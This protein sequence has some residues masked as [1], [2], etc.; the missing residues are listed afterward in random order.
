MNPKA[1]V[2]IVTVTPVESKSVIQA[3]KD[4]TGNAPKMEH[5]GD[6]TYHNLGEVNGMSVYMAISQMGSGGVGGSQETVRKGIEALRP[7]SVIMVGIAFG[8]NP[9]KQRIGDILV[10]Q[11]LR[12]YDLQRVGKDEIILRGD[13]PHGSA[14]LFNWLQSAF[15]YWDESGGRFKPGVVLTG[16]KLVDN[17]D[18]RNQLLQLEKEAIGG[19]ME[20]T[21]LY[22]ASHDKKVDWIL[23]KAI[24]DWADGDKDNP[25]KDDYQKTAAHNAANFVVFALQQVAIKLEPITSAAAGIPLSYNAPAK[26]AHSNLPHQPYFFG[27]AKELA[28]IAEAIGPEART[29]GALIDG[30]GGIGKTSLAIRAGHLAPEGY[31]ARKLFLS[32]KVRE[33]TPAGEQKLE[34]FM[35]PNFMALLTELARELGEDG[36]EKLPP[37]ER[38]MA[39]RNTLTGQRVLLVVD[40]LE[41]FDEKERVRLYQFLSHLPTTCKAI[42]T[43]RRRSDVDART[44]RLD[45]LER[46]EALEL[47]EELA[48]L[49]RHLEAA[50][51]KERNDLYETTNGNPLLI[52]WT[53]GQ[54][55]R[56]HCRSVPDAITFLEAAP[57]D[58]DPLEYI[59]G[60]LLDSFTDSE[61]AVLVALT[62]FTLPAK[63]KWIAETAGIAEKAAQTA[64]EDLA[65]RAL[66]IA[67]PDAEK[68]LLPPLAA[69]FLRRKCPELLAD[70]GKRLAD[71]VFALVM[72]NGY[73]EYKHFPILE[74]E[75]DIIAVTIPMFLQGENGR[76]QKVCDGL[77]D[78]MNFS[79]RWDELANL[80]QQG[81]EKAVADGDAYNAGCRAYHQGFLY[82]LW[83]QANEVLKAAAHCASHWE[84]ANFS[85]AGEKVN[86]TRLRGL[87][88]QLEKNYP[89]AM[90]AHHESLAAWR[91]IDRESEEV[92]MALNDLALVEWNQCNYDASK[93]YFLEALRIAKKGNYKESIATFTG[94]LAR[95][96]LDCEDWSGAETL[97]R[98]S[99]S[100]TE[101]LGRM[102]LIASD[103]RN[104]AKALAR[105]GKPQKGL[106]YAQRAVE[107]FSLLRMPDN[108]AN[109]QDILAECGG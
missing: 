20:G 63:I 108:L 38:A 91:A 40:N 58:N 31:F 70:A 33:L 89:A 48:T 42:V 6:R 85:E 3:F 104:L 8:V 17:V 46:N 2:L 10:S 77:L 73:H 45:R 72:E 21:G 34:D 95:L 79:G 15:L 94:N 35:L 56:G 98:K 9:K 52:K 76:L 29:W 66:L 99:L 16:E 75:W 19:E 86:A 87:G 107:I 90:A 14:R 30:P 67:T 24:C 41:T 80:N 84:K 97:A 59:F 54:L 93:R 101:K 4:A 103:S 69:T 11:Q 64:L 68:Y 105:Q 51:T 83:G 65:D 57:K 71:S 109:A 23:V 55:G 102:E 26:P 13:K 88:H 18:Y 62:Y 5:I 37:N 100:L 92:A 44:I 61:K 74:A 32:A 28:S 78:F 49:N 27:R 43:S 81:E 50:T 22:V 106:P 7:D 12:P 60:D 25:D 53:V 36:I 82:Y 1:D 39:V 47:L 96:T